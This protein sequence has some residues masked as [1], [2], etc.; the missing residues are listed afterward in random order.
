MAG[1][2]QLRVLNVE[3]NRLGINDSFPWHENLAN[4]LSSC[5]RLELLNLANNKIT[6]EGFL[7]LVYPIVYA[8]GLKLLD[9]RY[10]LIGNGEV[11]ELGRQMATV[12]NEGLLFVELAGNRVQRGSVDGLT[13][14]LKKNREK[15]P[16]T[17]EKLLNP[18]AAPN[19]SEDISNPRPS[20]S[21]SLESIPSS[22]ILIHLE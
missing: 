7:R 19:P 15:N 8:K 20:Q 22:G 1:H 2:G 5:Q 16:I 11:E 13:A 6:G 4:L 21:Q 18:P 9:L 17:I 10:N 14:L 3:H 12:G